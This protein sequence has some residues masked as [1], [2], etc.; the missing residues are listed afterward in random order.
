MTHARTNP[1]TPASKRRLRW[2]GVPDTVRAAIERIA[3]SRVIHAANQ[4]GGFSPGLAARL[5]LADGRAVFAKAIDGRWPT[6]ARFYRDEARIAAALPAEVPA[7]RLLGSFDDDAW[8][9][10]VFE[11][12]DGHEPARPWRATELTP[13]L[14]ALATLA[15]VATPSPIELPDDHPRL[16]GWR[17]IAAA[18]FGIDRLG[19]A[20][21]WAADR[22][23]RLVELE[24][25]GLDVA[26]GESLVH[27]DLFPH[28]VLL[29]GERAVIVD[30]PHARLGNP[31]V[32]LVML[33]STVAV[34]GHEPEPFLTAHPLACDVDPHRVDALLAAYSGFCV[35]GAIAPTDPAFR[36]IAEAK[37]ALGRD[38]LTWLAHRLGSR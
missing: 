4:A 21:P 13:V 15:R 7:P 3:G 24:D 10:M 18:P 28:N 29:A 36:P 33:L 26:R 8:V 6:E 25:D 31:L 5:R 1:D 17:G 11:Y 2:D 38:A 37:H 20:F 34:S 19:A 14:D 27:F 16:G 23:D 30:W 35:A 9:G 32:D 22:L 12:V